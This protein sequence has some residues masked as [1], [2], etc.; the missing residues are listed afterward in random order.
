MVWIL[1][2]ISILWI[3]MGCFY[4]LYTDK[5]REKVKGLLEGAN[6]RV[7]GVAAGLAGL[8]LIFAAFH[9]HNTWFIAILGALGVAKGVLLFLNTGNIYEKTMHWLL[10][11]ASDQT[12]RFLGIIML[13][14][15]T[16]LFSW[17]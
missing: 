3:V 12:Y 1:Y 9:S 4:I 7:L 5:I 8:L 14:L 15:G 10:E 2:L 17:A 6:R 11:S 16:A 13:I